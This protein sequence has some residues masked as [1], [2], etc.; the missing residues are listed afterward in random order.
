MPELSM[1]LSERD[2]R[3]QL[4]RSLVES[5][6]LD[7]KGLAAG[8]PCEIAVGGWDFVHRGGRVTKC[9]SG[10]RLHFGSPGLFQVFKYRLL[11]QAHL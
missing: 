11:A 7:L 5:R 4:D 8:D 10:F 2:M 1:G 9:G 6:K 3:Q